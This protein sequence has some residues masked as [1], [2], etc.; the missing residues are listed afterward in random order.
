MF[1]AYIP[2]SLRPQARK[3]AGGEEEERPRPEPVPGPPGAE[4]VLQVQE[5]EHLLRH[6]RPGSSQRPGARRQFSRHLEEQLRDDAL[7]SKGT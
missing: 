2:Q 3:G 7:P 5:D 6:E 1:A 4:V